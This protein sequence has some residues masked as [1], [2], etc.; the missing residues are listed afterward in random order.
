MSAWLP[1]LPR[2]ALAIFLCLICFPGKALADETMKSI[3]RLNEIH[4]RLMDPKQTFGINATLSELETLEKKITPQDQEAWGR[5][6]FLRG[7]V[8]YKADR[9]KDSIPP[10]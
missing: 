8:L 2:G 3:D 7:F 6:N 10:S 1:K 4:R 9:A 5:L